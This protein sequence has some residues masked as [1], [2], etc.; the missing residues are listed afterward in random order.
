MLPDLSFDLGT[1]HRLFRHSPLLSQLCLSRSASRAVEPAHV[2]QKYSLVA[3]PGLYLAS[4]TKTISFFLSCFLH[5]PRQRALE[6]AA[7]VMPNNEGHC[8]VILE[9]SG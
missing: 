3:R 2:I 6:L 1:W 5:L 4:S 8:F 9:T 7:L